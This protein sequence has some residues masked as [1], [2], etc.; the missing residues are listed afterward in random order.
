VSEAWALSRYDSV[1]LSLV[2]PGC[3]AEE[4]VDCREFCATARQSWHAFA[5][6]QC[7]VLV[8]L[9]GQHK[10]QQMGDKRASQEP[11]DQIP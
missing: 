6:S 1:L 5:A 4:A 2:F 3:F 11:Q 10:G 9:A 8:Y 7:L